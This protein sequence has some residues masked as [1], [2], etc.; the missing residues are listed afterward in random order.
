[1][2]KKYLYK[3]FWFILLLD[4]TFLVASYFLAYL[5]RFDFKLFST[6]YD[7][8]IKIMPIALGLKIAAMFYFDLYSGMWR[9][10]GIKDLTNILKSF[11]SSYLLLM[12]Y[13]LIA[14]RFL[15][16]SRA[17]FIIDSILNVF[18]IGG[19]RLLVR[20]FFE[21]K[22]KISFIKNYDTN[23]TTRKT[24]IIGAGNA[25]E[26]LLREIK[27]NPSSGY[28]AVGFLDDKASKIGRK[29][30]GVPVLGTIKDTLIV[31]RKYKIDE[32]IIA[33]PSANSD[34]L[35]L[36]SDYCKKTK[37]RYKILPP[38]NHII[39]QDISLKALK[40]VSY[41]DLLGRQQVKL[42]DKNINEYLNNKT[43]LVTGAGGSIGSVLCQKIANYKPSKIILFEI[44]ETPLY[45]IE[46]LLKDNFSYINFVPIIGDIKDQI[47]LNEVFEAYRPEIVFH[48]AAYKHVPMM[49]HN[50][51]QAFLN[52]VI[53]TKILLEAVAKHG[54]NKFILVS[55][56]KAV[57]P[58]SVMGAT[59]RL[60]ELLT[61]SYNSNNSK[62]S[63]MAVRFGNVLGSSGS[64]I[65]LFE[66]QIRKG[67]PL[68]ITHP[69]I[70][71]FF[72]TIPE[73][74]LL[75]LQSGAIGVGGEIFVLDM[76]EQKKILDVATEMI[77]WH[78][79]KPNI[80]I[81]ISYTGLR[82]GEK[83]Y[84]ELYSDSEKLEKTS[85]SKIN[86][87]KNGKIKDIC[88]S[89]SKIQNSIVFENS[90]KAKIK[91]LIPECRF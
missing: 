77:E 67:G 26:K 33:I 55:T 12:L 85:H 3:N 27:N 24:L 29:I 40:K 58:T 16:F 31:V 70:K 54:V 9:Y 53:G 6:G 84:E 59:K 8:F 41:E 86:V 89:V 43:V 21:N 63:F 10:T 42:D 50:P 76:G 30:H 13:I 11:L 71:R 5:I 81:K 48:A 36:I 38:L 60:A 52:N 17:V 56:D 73:A 62:T 28:L 82:P 66:K 69:D 51:R 32:I 72:M 47:L 68:T 18:F 39:N 83:L 37:V 25:G 64:V 14:H 19:A 20:Y 57:N 45:E 4:L 22:E 15:G 88:S 23:I 34:S 91:E 74:C 35:K 65:P 90:I 2:Y 80:D 1:V 46:M 79:L 61:L 44:A 75:I 49:E 78:G 7:N 87:L